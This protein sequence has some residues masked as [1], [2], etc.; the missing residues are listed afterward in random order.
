ESLFAIPDAGGNLIHPAG[1]E[2]VSMDGA[3]LF[4]GLAA[5]GDRAVERGGMSRRQAAAH[6]AIAVSTAITWAGTNPRRSGASMGSSRGAQRGISRSAGWW[7]SL[8]RAASS[9]EAAT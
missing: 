8:P 6:F 5:A 7:R 2:E 4:D 3:T 1:W 9:V